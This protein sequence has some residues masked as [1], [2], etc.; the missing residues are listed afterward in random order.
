MTPLC[1]L[2]FLTTRFGRLPL[3]LAAVLFVRRGSPPDPAFSLVD[4]GNV[5]DLLLRQLLVQLG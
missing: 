5:V 1:L 2:A 4:L 3:L